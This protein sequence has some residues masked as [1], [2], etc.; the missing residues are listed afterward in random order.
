MRLFSWA[1]IPPCSGARRRYCGYP[2]ALVIVCCV[3]GFGNDFVHLL[4]CMQGELRFIGPHGP[5]IMCFFTNSNSSGS[6]SGSGSSAETT[7]SISRGE[8]FL[9]TREEGERAVGHVSAIL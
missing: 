6:D 5:C 9:L 2:S 7:K 3:K 4:S 8:F 1:S